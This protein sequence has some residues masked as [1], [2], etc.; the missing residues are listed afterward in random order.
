MFSLA[1][2]Q[3][4]KFT[5]LVILSIRYYSG[6]VECS[7]GAYVILNRDGWLVTASHILEPILVFQAHKQAIADYENLK[8]NI[9]VDKRLNTKQRRHEL[10]KL[11]PNP[12]WITNYSYWWEYGG[13]AYDIQ[14]DQLRDIA[15]AR[16]MPFDPS[17]VSS[18][19]TFWNPDDSLTPGTSLCKLGF[20]F[21]PI[22][23]TFDQATGKFQLAPETFPVPRFP[24]DGILTRGLEILDVNTGQKAEFFEMST[25]GLRGQSGGPVFDVRAR[26]CGIQSRTNIYPLGFS[27]KINRDGREVTEHQFLNIGVAAHVKAILSFLN[28]HGVAV[29]VAPKSQEGQ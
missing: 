7:N 12:R 11:R 1:L 24:L 2:K 9:E 27:P 10:K 6:E 14:G 20:P 15:I 13:A 3:A 26:V 4:E 17:K 18:Y 16:L 29:T 23:A 21:H 22:K 28:I 25:P 5:G 19:P 8:Q